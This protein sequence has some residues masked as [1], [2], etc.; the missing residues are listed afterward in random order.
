MTMASKLTNDEWAQLT[1]DQPFFAPFSFVRDRIDSV[2]ARRPEAPAPR[3]FTAEQW[4]KAVADE[5]AYQQMSLPSVFIPN[6]RFRLTAPKPK[7]PDERV[8]AILAHHLG[9][10]Y[11]VK[12]TIA[13]EIVADHA[14]AL[15]S[16]QREIEAL[17]AEWDALKAQVDYL[18]HRYERHEYAPGGVDGCSLCANTRMRIASR[19]AEKGGEA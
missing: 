15:A 17:K 3:T 7:M 4:E 16:K 9:N 5:A 12:H 8:N 2:L 13:A 14:A 6:L 19:A 18:T 11:V 1:H 10:D